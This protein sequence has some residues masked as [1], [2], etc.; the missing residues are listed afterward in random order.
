MLVHDNIEITPIN[1][2]CTSILLIISI[3]IGIDNMCCR[4]SYHFII[5]VDRIYIIIKLTLDSY[6]TL[7]DHCVNTHHGDGHVFHCH[8]HYHQLYVQESLF[9]FCQVLVG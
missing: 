3:C 6:Y 1:Y 4:A 8:C 2:S 9:L 5:L 7:D